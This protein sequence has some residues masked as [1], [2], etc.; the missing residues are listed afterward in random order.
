MMPTERIRWFTTV[1]ADRDMPGGA[2]RVAGVLAGMMNS[3]TG[4]L[5]PS[6]QTISIRSTL[7]ERAVRRV[8]AQLSAAGYL[9]IR[10]NVGGRGNT[11]HY[12]PLFPIKADPGD[13]VTKGNPDQGNTVCG[14]SDSEATDGQTE[15]LNN[16]TGFDLETLTAETVNTDRAVPKTLTVESPRTSNGTGKNKSLG[17]ADKKRFKPPTV[18]QVA[19]YGRSRGSNVDP[20]HF[21][22]YYEARGWKLGKTAMKD[23]K[24]A[25]RTW[26]K[27]NKKSAGPV[28]GKE[29]HDL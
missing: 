16:E 24:A 20:E 22:D 28:L 1:I 3:T 14:N 29:L 2:V 13:R 23:W 26:E 7:T 11:N 4:Q 12:V 6:V 5:N 17:T 27:N 10:E 19:V 9:E 18:E 15:T 25:F 21:V 8:L